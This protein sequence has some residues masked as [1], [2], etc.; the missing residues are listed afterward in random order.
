MEPLRTLCG[1]PGFHG[2]QFEYHCCKVCEFWKQFE[3]TA[4]YD[5]WKDEHSGTCSANHKGSA[6]KMEVD[7]IVEM[8]HRSETVY[9]VRYGN[10]VG[11]TKHIKVLLTQIHTKI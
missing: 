9:N 3:G 4:E 10:Y 1:T 7:S 6:G 11:E 5:E 8:F 2:T